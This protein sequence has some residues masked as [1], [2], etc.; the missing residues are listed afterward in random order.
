MGWHFEQAIVP[1][2]KFHHP[3]NE[4][5]ARTAGAG[6][7][8]KKVRLMQLTGAATGARGRLARRMRRQS[9]FRER[10]S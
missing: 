10:F 3:E 4:S 2:H 1:H 6:G 9:P 5:G 8:P 7:C